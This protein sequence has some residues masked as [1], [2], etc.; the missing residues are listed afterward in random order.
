MMFGMVAQDEARAKA[1]EIKQNAEDEA[2]K[3][4]DELLEE[5]RFIGSDSK[6]EAKLIVRTFPIART[7]IHFLIH[8]CISLSR[9]RALCSLSLSLKDSTDPQDHA[10][11]CARILLR[12]AGRCRS[13]GK[14]P[15]RGRCRKRSAVGIQSRATGV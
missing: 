14:G 6:A 12:I 3:I 15:H 5:A 8:V 10:C 9:A 4:R 1:M 7:Y 13:E 2:T 11:L